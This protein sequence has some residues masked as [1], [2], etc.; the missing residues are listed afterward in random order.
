MQVKLKVDGMTCGGCVRAVQNVLSAVDKVENVSV[1]LPTGEVLVTADV[2]LDAALL[3]AAVE[4][5]GYEA[6]T[7]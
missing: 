7:L 4:G 5:A 3:I 2:G 1:D 6:R